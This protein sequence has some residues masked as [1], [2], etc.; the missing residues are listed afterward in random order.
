MQGSLCGHIQEK[1]P[2]FIGNYIA[3]SSRCTKM[4][5]ATREALERRRREPTEWTTQTAGP[6]SVGNRMALGLRAGAP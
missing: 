2:N 5:E 4:A 3:F 6:T 1:C